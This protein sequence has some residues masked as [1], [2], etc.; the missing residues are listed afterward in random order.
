VVHEGDALEDLLHEADAGA[1]GQD[2]LVLNHPVKELPTADAAKNK[3]NEEK[4]ARIFPTFLEVEF[5][6]LNAVLLEAIIST[7]R[8]QPFCPPQ[9][10]HSR[11]DMFFSRRLSREKSVKETNSLALILLASFLSLII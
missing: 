7:E 9:G 6:A 4:F 2:E 1:L 10:Q 8:L 3:K 5:G 11:L